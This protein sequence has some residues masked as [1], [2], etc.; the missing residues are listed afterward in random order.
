MIKMENKKGFTLLELMGVMII[1]SLI[2]ILTFPNIVNQ[3]KKSKASNKKMVEDII[4]SQAE[5]YVSDNPADFS[6]D[7]YC[8]SIDTLIDNGY[9]KEDIINSSEDNLK[10]KYI[11]LNNQGS[12]IVK[13]KCNLNP[14]YIEDSLIVFLD[15]KRFKEEKKY[16]G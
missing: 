11:T 5:K 15:G 7:G 13:E 6:D 9:V 16:R 3:I 2:S 1:I 14:G 12:M 10:N 4:I 8:L